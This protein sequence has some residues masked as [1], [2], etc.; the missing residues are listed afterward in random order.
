MSFR[1][2]TGPEAST[3]LLLAGML[4]AVGLSICLVMNPVV[5]FFAGLILLFCAGVAFTNY[6]DEVILA[7][8]FLELTLGGNGHILE[9]WH[10]ISLRQAVLALVL[11]MFIA[12]WMVDGG[13]TNFSLR[14][15]P[16]CTRT[17]ILGAGMFLLFGL[18]LGR[19]RGNPMDFI[20]GD[21]HGLL[22]LAAAIPVFYFATRKKSNF[23]FAVG[24]FLVAVFLF[25]ALKT[26][27]YLA[28]LVQFVDLTGVVRIIKDLTSQQV[29]T[30]TGAVPLPRLY[31]MGDVFLAFALPLLISVLASAKTAFT[32]TVFGVA[33]TCVV[34]G[35]LFSGAR[36]LWLGTLLGLAVVFW[37]SN[38]SGKV[39]IILVIIV[40]F[41]AFFSFF[42]ETSSNLLRRLSIS[43]DMSEPSNFGRV[44]QFQPLMTMARRNILLGNGFGASVPDLVQSAEYP[45][46]YELQPMEL[47][48]KMGIVGCGIWILFF[49]W[50]LRDLWRAYKQ[51]KDPFQRAL[52]KGLV[53]G[54]S[55]L[56]FASATN[57]YLTSTPALCC[58]TYTALVADLLRRQSAAQPATQNGIRHSVMFAKNSLAPLDSV[59]Y[60]R[61]L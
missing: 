3:S 32:R 57:P 11:T 17:A 18:V 24:C 1:T 33:T 25:A 28:I 48:M 5:G 59:Q 43:F 49:F 54:M 19:V 44:R 53:A 38:V 16:A 9:F 22:F 26:L 41:S 10:V 40:I 36:G 39:R 47:L 6:L 13:S 20:L 14:K 42:P 46:S 55:A 34:L 35:L 29:I 12:A 4:V 21:A 52:S 15:C 8:L 27:A 30:D 50:L 60:R 23:N 58:I 37:F 56:L 31:V 2:T 51:A 45:W 7:I 61:T